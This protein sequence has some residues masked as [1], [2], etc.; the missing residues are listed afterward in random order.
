MAF[1]GPI[2]NV[3]VG[4]YQLTITPDRL[5]GRVTSAETLL[6]YGAIPLGSLLAGVLLE[7]LGTRGATAAIAAGMGVVAVA[8]TASRGVRRAPSLGAARPAA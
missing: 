4:A 8:A 3:A 2:W 5:L 7:T 1:V 6:A